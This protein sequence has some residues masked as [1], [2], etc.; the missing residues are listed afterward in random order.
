M[1]EG[2]GLD[3]TLE[4]DQ[5]LITIPK[6]AAAKELT[7]TYDT[8][9]L[10]PPS[11]NETLVRALQRTIRAATWD[12]PGKITAAEGGLKI[13]QSVHV[14][15]MIETWLADLRTALKPIPAAK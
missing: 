4:G 1:L 15:R 10:V 8:Q 2:L 7:I 13:K 3:W 6:V 14:H 5:I 12:N 9:G 11:D